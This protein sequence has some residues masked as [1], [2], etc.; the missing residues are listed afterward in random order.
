LRAAID[1]IKPQLPEAPGLG[2]QCRPVEIDLWLV[3]LDG[4]LG[5]MFWERLYNY[6]LERVPAPVP[7]AADIIVHF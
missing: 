3:D 4:Y 7:A 5:T 1:K 2:E 6:R